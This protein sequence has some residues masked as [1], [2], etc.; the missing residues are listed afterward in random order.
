[1]SDC[2]NNPSQCWEPCGE[3]GKSEEHVAV[4]TVDV[5]RLKTV[6]RQSERYM[7]HL[8]FCLTEECGE[9]SQVVGKAGRFGLDDKNPISGRSNLEGII[10]EVHDVVAVYQMLMEY[11][12][13][14]QEIDQSLL[15][16]KKARV[17]H[18]MGLRGIKPI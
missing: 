6:A 5:N 11:F 8:L 1:M 18:F 13:M 7:S 16:A 14:D 4:S 17:I 3:L 10:G 2:C 15:D 9:V 12:G